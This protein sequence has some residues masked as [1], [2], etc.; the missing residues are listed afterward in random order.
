MVSSEQMDNRHLLRLKPGKACR[1]EVKNFI[2]QVAS[3][4]IHSGN[5]LRQLSLTFINPEHQ[6]MFGKTF[7]YEDDLE[8]VK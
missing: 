8:P 4:R 7:F 3:E 2:G 5:G 1:I 6:K